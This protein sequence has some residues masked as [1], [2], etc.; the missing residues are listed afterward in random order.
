LTRRGGYRPGEWY[1]HMSNVNDA[2][3][4]F[5]Y[6]YVRFFRHYRTKKFVFPKPG[7]KFIRLKIRADRAKAY[8]ERKRL[9]SKPAA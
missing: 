3:K 5:V 4:K 1:L 7:K 6:V 9:K 8:Q 2:R